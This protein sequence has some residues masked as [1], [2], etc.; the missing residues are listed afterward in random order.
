MGGE[1]TMARV[2]AILGKPIEFPK[3]IQTIAT[4]TQ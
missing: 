4:L 2:D 1:V 3:L